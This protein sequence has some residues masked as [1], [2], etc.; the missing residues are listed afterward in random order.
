MEIPFKFVSSSMGWIDK[1][2]GA[3]KTIIGFSYY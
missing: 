3:I 1:L 2:V